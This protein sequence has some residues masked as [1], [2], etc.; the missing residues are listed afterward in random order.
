MRTRHLRR[1]E[2]SAMRL[3]Q[4]GE[5]TA[6]EKPWD[7]WMG[8][9]MDSD[10]YIKD[11]Q[12]SS[13]RAC[14]NDFLLSS[15]KGPGDLADLSC[16]DLE[17]L[18]A[19]IRGTILETTH[20]NGGHL[21]SS[22]GAVEIIIAMHRVF[23]DSAD[24]LLF[25]VGHQALAHKLLTGR[26]DRFST[27]RQFGG[28]SGFPRRSESVYDVYDSGHAS[29]S[30]SVAYGI[31]SAKKLSND[32]GKVA[33][34]IGDAS[35]SGGMAFEALNKIGEDGDNI[36]V[37]LNDN[38]MSISKNVGAMSLYLG[39]IRL[40]KRYID[41]RDLLK[42]HVSSLGDLGHM[43]ADF[44]G[45]VK[46][47]V[48]RMLVAGTLF[49]DMSITYIGPIDGHDITAL[50]EAM[51]AA[52][53]HEG[54]V[55]IHAVTTKGKGY[56]LAERNPRKF[57][58]VAAFDLDTGEVHNCFGSSGFTKVFSKLMV[59]E[60]ERN[61]NLVALTAAMVD[62]TGLVEFGERFPNRL[63]DVG[64]AEE[65]AA[66]MAAGLAIEGKTPVLAIY[67]TFMQRAFDQIVTNIA[68]PNLHVVMCLD[69][70]GIVGRDGSTHHGL[71]DMAYLRLV[72]NMTILAP[73][74]TQE[75]AGAFATAV[76]CIDGPVAIRYPRKSNEI[77]EPDGTEAPWEHHRA[78]LCRQ[79][80]DVAILAVGRMVSHA[81]EA[82]EI[83]EDRGIGACVYDM[84]WVKPVDEDAIAQACETRLVVTI[85]DGTVEGGFASA[86][87]DYMGTLD[88]CGG[89]ACPPPVVHLGIPDEFV[90]HGSEEDLFESL[91]L[92]PGQVAG[93]IE[94]CLRDRDRHAE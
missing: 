77:C 67:S 65:H 69:R 55:L 40:S 29:D 30:L 45:A 72:P 3:W 68:L 74:S 41:T 9:A 58:G 81:L 90:E 86:V 89:K 57:H 13:E 44:T 59:A 50:E 80:R 92:Q 87:L 26:L 28:I 42:K 39:K 43:F 6:A 34:L 84:R 64:I 62:G 20:S 4:G 54:P 51:Q 24:R 63:F 75:L 93:T 19:E 10:A 12:N 21:A 2:I 60:G 35:I 38:E 32:R 82:A 33:V 53:D 48:K 23:C 71:F 16:D 47:S 91:G 94:R 73:S 17:Q 8:K 78:V 61:P 85:E 70:A 22:L 76:H 79:G 1:A 25:D 56:A 15:I 46:Q 49:E 66:A 31:A 83:L 52:R 5:A 18:A 27:F 11:E 14:E 88:G 36:T 37:I 7:D